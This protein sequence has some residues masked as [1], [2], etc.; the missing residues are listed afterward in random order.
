RK[1][2]LLLL[3]LRALLGHLGD[4]RTRQQ[5]LIH[6]QREQMLAIDG[7]HETLLRPYRRPAATL[8]VERTTGLQRAQRQLLFQFDGRDGP[9]GRQA[10]DDEILEPHGVGGGLRKAPEYTDAGPPR[11]SCFFAANGYARSAPC[12]PMATSPRCS[13]CSSH[14]RPRPASVSVYAG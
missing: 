13:P 10:V 12:V 1:A 2:L 7:V 8:H 4:D 5:L 9:V 6:A 11:Q 14:G 3:L